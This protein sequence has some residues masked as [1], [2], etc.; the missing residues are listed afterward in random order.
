V[1]A[2]LCFLFLL[3]ECCS[4]F[5]YEWT[6]NRVNV[7]GR[8]VMLPGPLEVSLAATTPCQLLLCMLSGSS[9]S[10]IFGHYY[11]YMC[12]DLIEVYCLYSG[13]WDVLHWCKTLW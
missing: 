4:D 8:G 9:A 7:F 1:H 13:W 12:T 6:P 3:Q 10:K 5:S 2:P 11:M